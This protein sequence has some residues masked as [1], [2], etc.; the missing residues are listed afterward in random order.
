[1]QAV[2]E[3]F[4]KDDYMKALTDLLD[5]RQTGSVEEYFKE[6]QELQYQVCMHNE[7]YGDL[8]FASQFVN[9]LK[10]EIKY[11][12][13]SQVLEDVD[14]A[15]L[16]AKI[17]Q[18]IVERTKTKSQR[19][20]AGYRNTTQSTKPD[21][22]APVSNQHLWRERQLRDFRKA[23]GLCYF[24]G[25]KYDPAHSE[26]CTKKARP[27]VN[28]LAMNDL[29][30][31]LTDEVL[32]QLA[33]EDTLA[34]E[35]FYLSLNA[36][37]G[38]D[39]KECIQL[40]SLVK[41]KVMLIL[42]DS[43]S[44]H[45]F[46][47]AAF[48]S[49]AG[50]ETE[51]TIP[52]QVRLANGDIL[53]SDEMISQLE[54]WCQGHTLTMDVRVLDMGAYDAILGFDWLKLH[55][56]MQCHW[57]Q[58]T[59]E[60]HDKGRNIKLQGVLPQLSQGQPIEAEQLWKACKG[61]DIWAFAVVEM[62]DN[63]QQEEIPAPI[64]DLIQQYSDLFKDPTS[65]PPQRIYDYTISLYPDAVPVNCRPYKYSPQH[66]SEIER[67]VQELLA[68]GLIEHSSSPFASPVLL[69]QKKDGSWIFCVDYRRLNALTIKNRFPMPVIEEILD[70]LFGAKYFTKLEM[71]SG[72]HQVKMRVEDEFKTAFKTHHGHYQFKVMPFGLT[73]APSTFQ[74][75][76]NELLQPFLRKF[77]IVF[78]DDILI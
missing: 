18:T 61:N 63:K 1:V 74:C 12:V 16:L 43:G 48:V 62:V 35:F 44:S 5:L 27:Q 70:E 4:G 77:V 52:K 60:F 9:G 3:K 10:D 8:F 13:Q 55:S 26:V 67:Q 56:P 2:E 6:F 58:R 14:R 72:N 17:Q 49:Q 24:C 22:K 11:T 73:N 50:L 78:L 64:Q 46:V 65:L 36:I 54:W 37:S 38:T 7:G 20:N 28:A 30:Q 41:N 75:L 15:V 34:E 47:S 19:W 31:N 42:V 40:K 57:E 32:N 21:T 33:V 29:D 59:M 71:R 66:K 51:S 68:A 69:V 39:S 45:S 25:D 76:M 23:N 53:L